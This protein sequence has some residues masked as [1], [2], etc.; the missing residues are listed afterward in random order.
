MKNDDAKVWFL[1][2]FMTLNNGS[3]LDLNRHSSGGHSPEA[4]NKA[5]WN[6][7]E[8]LPTEN[9]LP[10]EEKRGTQFAPDIKQKAQRHSKKRR[11][12]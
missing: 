10:P 9:R 4:R 7:K 5:D 12:D 3:K 6:G 8:K 1:E 2:L 11:Q